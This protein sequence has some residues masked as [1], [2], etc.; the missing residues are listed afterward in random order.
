[1]NSPKSQNGE[2]EWLRNLGIFYPLFFGMA[3]TLI[4][5]LLIGFTGPSSL[6]R[7]GA[8]PLVVAT[9]W[10]ALVVNREHAPAGLM[11][12]ALAVYS[13]VHLLRYIS[14]ALVERWNFSDLSPLS[15][16]P[17][18]QVK[19]DV[20]T[21][22]SRSD[23]P[24]ARL[25]FG[26]NSVIC[27]RHIDTPHE[28]KNVPH[29]SDQDTNYIPSKFRFLVSR[30][31]IIVP[32]YLL[33]DLAQNSPPLENA[34]LNLG[35]QKIPLLM[36]LGQ[37][38]DQELV[39]RAGFTTAFWIITYFCVRVLIGIPEVLAVGLGFS[40]VRACRPIFG[41]VAEAYTVRQFWG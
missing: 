22:D 32:C 34:H 18:Q 13:I 15:S 37:V 2:P 7:L 25:A 12:S 35:P 16:I 3:Q 14:L 30:A 20:A 1:M 23:T 6:V 19:G 29:F 10:T 17:A 4:N 39:M 9:A 28:V 24:R 40:K 33:L 27:A 41:A 11:Q 38:S 26:M 21:D 5:G 31:A 36:R 8:V